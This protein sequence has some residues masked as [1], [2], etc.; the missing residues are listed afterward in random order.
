MLP[1]YCREIE[2]GYCPV[3]KKTVGGRDVSLKGAFP[4]D[5]E[6]E[7]CLSIPRRLGVGTALLRLSPDGGEARDYPLVFKGTSNDTD[8]YTVSMNL[9]AAFCGGED[10]LF[11]YEFLFFRGK[12]VLFSDTW[13][14]VDCKPVYECVRRFRLLVYRSDF[15]TPTWFAGGVMYHIFVD[16]FCRGKGEVG[17]REDAILN[18]D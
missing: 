4:L 3:V 6:I 9:T 10:G 18:P 17:T 7:F 13:N 8:E 2:E 15:H 12:E 5:T 16:R 11:Y 14:N 1:K